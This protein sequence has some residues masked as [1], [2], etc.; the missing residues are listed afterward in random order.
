MLR[1]ELSFETRVAIHVSV[2]MK[3]ASIREYI[4]YVVIEREVDV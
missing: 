4:Q 1:R 2:I 3:Q